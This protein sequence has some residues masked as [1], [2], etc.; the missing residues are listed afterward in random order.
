MSIPLSERLPADRFVWAYICQRA[1][2]RLE[3]HIRWLWASSSNNN[4]GGFSNERKSKSFWKT[5]WRLNIPN[6]VKSFAW[7]ASKNILPTKANLNLCRRHVVADSVCE[8]CGVESE[9][10]SHAL[11]D[12][13]KAQEVWRISGLSFDAHGL[14]FPEFIEFLWHLKF[15]KCMGDDVLE[16]VIMVAWCIWYNRNAVHQGKERQACEAIL[17]KVKIMHVGG[18][19]DGQF[20]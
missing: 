10:S 6:K 17:H 3:A 8:A 9:S 20:Y 5:L 14:V 4:C 16:F 19:P 7:N 2:S 12:S 18:I 15:G 11:W 13:K 1:I